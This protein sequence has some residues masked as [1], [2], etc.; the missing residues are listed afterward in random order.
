[1]AVRD[2]SALRVE[3]VHVDDSASAAAEVDVDVVDSRRTAVIEWWLAGVGEQIRASVSVTRHTGD[4]VSA[5]AELSRD[6][7]LVDAT[8]CPVLIVPRWPR[9]DALLAA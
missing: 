9:S 6:V 3:I 5:L 4:P 7:E 8:H 2:G 1:V